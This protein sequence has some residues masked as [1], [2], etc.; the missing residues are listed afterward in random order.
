MKDIPEHGLAVT[1]EA[2]P[3]ERTAIA[4]DTGLPDLKSLY[5]RFSLSRR[6]GDRFDVTG[7]ISAV[8]TEIC[9]VSLEPFDSAVD[10]PIEIGFVDQAFVER[11]IRDPRPSRAMR[12]TGR[13][14]SE[15]DTAP[16]PVPGNDDQVDAP[17][18]IVDGRIDLGAVAVE[19]LTL[20]RDPYPRQPGI[21]FDDIK[22]GAGEDASPFSALA[23]L[24]GRP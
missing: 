13:R 22:L 6:A 19:F 10:A 20:A 23:Q 2:N 11:E 21:R 17:E 3:A 8:V 18:P 1:I 12:Q 7:G 15:H 24:K 14:S 9:G 5:G 4:A 16:R